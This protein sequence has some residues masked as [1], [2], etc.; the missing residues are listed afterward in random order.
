MSEDLVAKFRSLQKK[1]EQREVKHEM[2]ER[3]LSKLKT[4]I[5]KN[6]GKLGVANRV[7]LEVKMQKLK[8]RLQSAIEEATAILGE[9]PVDEFPDAQD[10]R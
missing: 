2:L 4:E 1:N 6:L 7:E 9:T 10:S 5:K 3:D 8:A